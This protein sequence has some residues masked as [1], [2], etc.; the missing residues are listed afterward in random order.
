MQREENKKQAL[1]ILVI[2]ARL[3]LNREDF[4]CRGMARL[5][6][7]LNNLDHNSKD[8]LK[9]EPNSKDLLKVDPNNKDLLKVDPN[10]KDLLKVDPNNKDLLKVDP[11]SKDLLKVD[12]NNKD[13]LKVDPN[14]KDLLKVDPNSKDLLKV[15]PNNKDLLK[16]D[17]NKQGP[18]KVGTQKP[19][20]PKTGN[21]QQGSPRTAPQQKAVGEP[22]SQSKAEAKALCPVCNTTGLNLHTKEPPNQNTC[23]QCKTVVCSS[24]GFSPP[25][26]GGTEWLCLTCQM[27]RALG[28]SDSPGYPKK[29][30]PSPNK[31]STSPAP[32]KKYTPTAGSP[33]RKPQ[34]VSGSQKP[35]E[36]PGQPGSKQGNST[37]FPQQQP[38]QV[39]A[40]PRK[41]V[42]PPQ[43][44]PPKQS[45]GLFGFGVPKSQPAPSKPEESVSGKMFGFGSSIFS[46]ASTL[47]TSA[48]QDQPRTTPPAS[49]KM[50]A[51]AQASTKILP[52]KETK[53]PA[54]QKVE[55][56]KAEKP[57]PQQSNVPPTVQAKV[58][59]LPSEP[60]KGAASSQPVPKANQS[61]C[62][63]CKVELNMGSKDPPNYNTCTECK[64]MVCNLCGFNP[65]PH[66]T[67]VKEW[68]CLNCQMK[69]MEP[70]RP[71]VVK[72][73]P[74]PNKAESDVANTTDPQKLSS[75][76][77]AQKAPQE[78]QRT[79]GS[80]K[81]LEDPSQPGRKQSTANSLPQKQHPKGGASPAKA[82]TPQAPP[83][84][85]ES[86]GLFGFGG[87]KSE[88]APSKPEESVSGKM[89]GFGSSI[90]SSASTLIT[91]AVKDEHRTTP[92]ASPK[93]SAGAHASPKIPPAKETKPPAA[94]KVE[95][96]KAVHPQQAKV[97]LNIGSK[98]PPNYNTCTECKNMVCNLCGFNPMPN[99]TEVME[100][101]CLN[102]QMQRA[103]GVIEP[104]GLP[105]MKPQSS[106]NK[107]SASQNIGTQSHSA[108]HK[109]AT[110]PASPRKEPLFR[111]RPMSHRQFLRRFLHLGKR[112]LPH[113]PVYKKMDHQLV[114][115]RRT[116]QCQASSRESQIPP[117]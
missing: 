36:Q 39:E 91:S 48:V 97:K 58:D 6:N 46:S 1:S 57:Q 74:S 62:P 13:L 56:K 40:S 82:V 42:P 64:N 85:Q 72:P 35:P 52:A 70:S 18:S 41:S 105:M 66:E 110:D 38:S 63:L 2:R 12:P 86:G 19:E 92:P 10:S 71:P 59:K 28:G 77:P 104:P 73:Q 99:A 90:F 47:I 4:S 117:H 44:Q 11:N 23:T 106:P 100:W 34:G 88:P 111:M 7:H 3:P 69:R 60:S 93:M 112:I 29:P 22:G 21:H 109:V 101:L 79:P 45:G 114:Q 17:P 68:L 27:Q 31:I 80:L 5:V 51:G 37:S 103:L 65:M 113:Q 87:P 96:R 84:K 61:T 78:N 26:T 98:D 115:Q 16:V 24:C 107:D 54:S 9:V 33:Q 116:S 14:S 25:D 55:M 30:Q 32:L 75:P 89:F 53:L 15:D 108:P 76:K 67:E 102:C 43:A 95:E 49:P 81:P 94:Q 8:L 83:P 50:S 20:S